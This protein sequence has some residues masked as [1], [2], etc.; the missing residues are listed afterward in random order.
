MFGRTLSGRKL[1]QGAITTKPS[2]Y[3][4][5]ILGG[6]QHMQ[7]YQGTVRANVKAARRARGKVAKAA[8]KA[9]R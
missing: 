7:L 4:L 1:D 5:A 3:E 8:R 9:N 6:L 2:S